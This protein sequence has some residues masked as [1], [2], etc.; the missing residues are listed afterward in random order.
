LFYET[1]KFNQL[2][3]LSKLLQDLDL[4]IIDNIREEWSK[5]YNTIQCFWC[6]ASNR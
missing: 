4:K 6:L 1:D 2:L 3:Y 5:L